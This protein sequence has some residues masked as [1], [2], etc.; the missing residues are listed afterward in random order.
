MIGTPSEDDL[1][2]VTDDK[3]IKYLRRFRARAPQ[4]LRD[5]YPE[6][7]DDALRLLFSML[8]FNPFNRPNVDQLLKDPYFDEVRAFSQAYDAP[9]EISLAFE[10]SQQYVG[11]PEI[12]QL[13]LQE[14]DHYRQLKRSGHSE[15]SPAPVKNRNV[16]IF[17]NKDNAY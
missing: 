1:S 4:N 3:A 8:Q 9:E 14:I 10:E 2:F 7:S 17:F 12:R 13:F 16:Q 15:V 5:R 11:M 6:C